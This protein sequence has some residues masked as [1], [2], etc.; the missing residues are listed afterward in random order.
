MQN[1]S[2]NDEQ[3]HIL[4]A[5]SEATGKLLDIGAWDAF[6]K[7]NSRALFEKGWSGVL[8]EPSPRPFASLQCQYWAEDRVQLIEA[9]VVINPNLAEVEMYISDDMV[10]TTESANY[11]KWKDCARFDGKVKVPAI[12]LERIFEQYG[13]FDFVSLDAE[14]TS[15]DLLRRLFEMGKRPKCVCVE[16]D[17]RM[18]E[19]ME[20]SCPLGYACV[21][22]SGENLVLVR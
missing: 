19:V 16:H 2:Q 17:D 22:V 4:A 7:S 21:Y 5:C 13:D 6:D 12:T 15:V 1:F 14:G 8:V 3:Q 11:E 18:S 20:A 10:S 9:A